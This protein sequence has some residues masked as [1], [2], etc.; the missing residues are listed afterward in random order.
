MVMKI[1]VLL[2]GAASALRLHMDSRLSVKGSGV[3]ITPPLR[4]YSETKLSKSIDIHSGLLT[5]V[6]LNLKVEKSA[7][8][9]QAHHGKETHIAECTALCKDK[10]V[11]RVC[12]ESDSMYASIDLLAARLQRTLR[13]Y[14]E[15]RIEGK[16]SGS[17]TSDDIAAALVAG[18]DGAGEVDED[19][20]E[21]SSY[22]EAAQFMSFEDE[23]L[24]LDEDTVPESWAFAL[25]AD[26]AP[27]NTAPPAGYEW[28]YVG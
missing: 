3:E 19:E 13:K 9:D 6:A 8:H 27:E 24:F 21:V 11:V 1:F 20:D 28:G 5:S 12:M 26:N 2:L 15:R 22:V 16:R 14:K 17:S 10:H 25:P 7:V 4:T 23:V 18:G